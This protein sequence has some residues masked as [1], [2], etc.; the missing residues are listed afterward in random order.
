M[1]GVSEVLAQEDSFSSEHIARL[2]AG[3]RDDILCLYG[4]QLPGT[5]L[6]PLFEQLF[7]RF[8]IATPVPAAP[9][10]PI[11]FQNRIEDHEKF[12]NPVTRMQFFNNALMVGERVGLY[13]YLL[14]ED[15]A[16]E[17]HRRIQQFPARIALT[18]CKH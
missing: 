15:A 10:S 11:A 4:A 17:E 6:E 18:H 14:E 16:L 5:G 12:S 9:M 3:L 2:T 7:R 13:R 8:G 1:R